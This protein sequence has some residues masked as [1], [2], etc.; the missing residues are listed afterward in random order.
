ML[1]SKFQF[2]K[3]R[4]EK[5]RKSGLWVINPEKQKTK[6]T[7]MPHGLKI[8]TSSQRINETKLAL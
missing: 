3:K 6:R 2:K 8:K 5:K 7:Q 4:K 1:I